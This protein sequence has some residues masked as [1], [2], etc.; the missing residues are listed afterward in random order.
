MIGPDL[1]VGPPNATDPIPEV[2]VAGQ[3]RTVPRKSPRPSSTGVI[4]GGSPVSSGVLSGRRYREPN[5]LGIESNQHGATCA[6]LG[7]LWSCVPR[8][9]GFVIRRWHH[10]NRIMRH[11]CHRGRTLGFVFL[12][13][14]SAAS[15]AFAIRP[16][17]FA[18]ISVTLAHS[19][20]RSSGVIGQ[21]S[22]TA[23]RTKA[24]SDL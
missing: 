13:S 10:T 19:Q 11:D 21:L 15:A 8:H 16:S 9:P 18:R 24:R 17:W 2:A 14:A 3:E 5:C 22:R 7:L 12:N 23:R 4:T 1:P 20:I 6:V